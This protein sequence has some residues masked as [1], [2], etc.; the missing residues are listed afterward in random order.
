MIHTVNSIEID[1]PVDAVFHLGTDVE[2][3]PALLSHYRYVRVLGGA[4]G[5][6]PLPR[7]RTVEMSASRTGIPVRWTATQT[8]DGAGKRIAYAHI[9]G[10]TRGMSVL[11][12][13]EQSAG[14]THVR[15]VHDLDRPAGILRIPGGQ[16]IA[17]AVFITHIADQTLAGIK[18]R[19][20]SDSHESRP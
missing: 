16:L 19:A 1:A 17:A 15:I 9:R 6:S 2:R 8:I 5:R 18:A 11:W 14:K 7:V 10:F 3:W 13:V 20:E 4:A 12:E